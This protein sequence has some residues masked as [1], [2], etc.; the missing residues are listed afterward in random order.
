M[1]DNK[2]FESVKTVLQ[3]NYKNRDQLLDLLFAQGSKQWYCAGVFMDFEPCISDFGLL[4]RIFCW[5]EHRSSRK[6]SI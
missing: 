4:V 3:E 2:M 1:K 5:V 6:L